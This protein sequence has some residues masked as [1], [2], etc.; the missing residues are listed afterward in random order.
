MAGRWP[1]VEDFEH[2][3]LTL[4]LQERE[5][6]TEW[7]AAGPSTRVLGRH[8]DAGDGSVRLVIELHDGEA[9]ESVV[10]P[11][12]AVC[13]STQVGC[14]VR[15]AFCASGAQ[16]LR[17]NLEAGEIL[18]Q[19]MHARRVNRRIDRLV[20][21][22]I[23]E[24]THNLEALLEVIPFLDRDGLV[25]VRRQTLSTVGSP[26]AFDRL[27]ELP[28]RPRVAL[29]LHA[30]DDKLRKQLLPHAGPWSVAQ[31]LDCAESYA[32]RSGDEVQVAWALL[33]GVNDRDED[34]D[35]WIEVMRGRPVFVNLIPWNPVEGM[36]FERPDRDRVR[37][38]LRT[39]RDAGVMATIRWSAGGE[40]DAAC[41]Q[42]RLRSLEAS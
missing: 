41:G 1:R 30:V 6:V 3:G 33:G 17:R 35:Q 42:L 7:I 32:A 15:C 24:P 21:M 25:P 29:S 40:A 38:I 4:S 10:M 18:E 27:L 31:L 23:G 37:H 39:L 34:L 20:F 22:G 9:I 14:A 36:P 2:S 26:K 16:G 5:Q 13:L 28:L 8:T 11:D 12:G 19:L